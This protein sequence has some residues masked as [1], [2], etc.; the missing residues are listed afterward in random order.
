MRAR[1]GG[2]TLLEIVFTVGLMAFALVPLVMMSRGNIGRTDH[3]M[4]RILAVNLSTRMIQR[5]VAVPYPQL[6]ALVT[7]SDFDPDQDPLLAPLT[8]P[9]DLRE[10]L[11]EYKK[12]VRFREVVPDALAVVEV[13]IGWQAKKDGPEATLKASQ[14]VMNPY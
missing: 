8:L 9:E 6:K 1:R 2:A 5:F 10:K 7:D 11:A 4:R 13:E 14:V 12:V 3:A